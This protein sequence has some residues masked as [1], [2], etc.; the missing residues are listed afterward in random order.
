MIDKILMAASD[1]VEERR[2]ASQDAPD[3]PIHG[4]WDMSR[5]S[6]DFRRV[7]A[8]VD[9]GELL[10]LDEAVDHAHHP[11]Q[12]IED[13]LE[14]LLQLPRVLHHVGKILESRDVLCKHVLAV[15]LL[16]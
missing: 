6:D 14:L 5:G 16:D 11:V 9:G 1:K 8:D 2:S 12:Q 13:C 7:M 15:E 10:E 4:R 3:D